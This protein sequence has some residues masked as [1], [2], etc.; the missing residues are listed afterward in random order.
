MRAEAL[1]GRYQSKNLHRV[2]SVKTSSDVSWQTEDVEPSVARVDAQDAK[3]IT[4][5]A[6]AEEPV[7]TVDSGVSASVEADPQANST[8]SQDSGA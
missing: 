5:T 1:N 4:V 7:L 3:V 8:L 6:S 2:H